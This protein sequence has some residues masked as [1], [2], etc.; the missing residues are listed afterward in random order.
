MENKLVPSPRSYDQETLLNDHSVNWKN[1]DKEK[2]LSIIRHNSNRSKIE[3]LRHPEVRYEV[4]DH[5]NAECIMCPRE[6]HK[7]GRPHGIMD[8]D[9]YMRSIDEVSLLGCKQVVLTGFG[10]PLV[11]KTLEKKISYAKDKGLRTYIITNASLLN[12]S[13]A[14]A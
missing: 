14:E 13:R 12:R 7:L 8:L 3:N 5:C 2:L 1:A 10:E 6:L 11:D 9:K 4:T